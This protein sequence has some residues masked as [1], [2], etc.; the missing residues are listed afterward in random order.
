MVLDRLTPQ[1]YDIN[2]NRLFVEKDLEIDH[3]LEC[4]REFFLYFFM[5]QNLKID[6]D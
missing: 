5:N 3:E 4:I 2:L 1:Q 6:T